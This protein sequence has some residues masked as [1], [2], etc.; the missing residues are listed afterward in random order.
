M[1]ENARVIA[2]LVPKPM[3]K[4]PK[5]MTAGES[6]IMVRPTETIPIIQATLRA[7][8]LPV[9]SAILGIIKNPTKAPKKSID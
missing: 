9:L 2:G 7:P 6:A 4:S 5:P 1:N 3:K 8:F